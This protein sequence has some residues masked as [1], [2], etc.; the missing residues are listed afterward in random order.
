[1]PKKKTKK[2]NIDDEIIIGYNTNITKDTP[3]KNSKKNNKNKKKNSGKNTKNNQKKKN[4]LQKFK[5]IMIAICKILLIIG[6]LV[7]IFA[8]LFI[9][10]V[11]NVT[12]IKVENANRIS[13]NT[14]ISLSEIQIGEN[15]FKINS[16]RIRSLI[17]HESYVEEIEVK[18]SFPGTVIITVTERTPEY[19]IE[20]E[21]KYIYIDKNGY[22]L[23]NNVEPLKLPILKGTITD[24]GT[25][26]MGERLYEEDLSK[27][28]DLIKIMD[29]LKNNN[30]SEKI[31]SIDISNDKNY[32]LEFNEQKKSVYLGDISNLSTK[33]LWIKYFMEQSKEGSGIVHLEA[34]NVYFSP[35]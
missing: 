34:K 11:F 26:T 31:T 2:Y 25:L 32:I 13:E 14:Y 5:K 27:F 29:G 30:I 9:S 8:F 20:K 18:K 17:K 33:M 22:A 24:F 12:E 6:I 7:G 15:I 3:Q 4:R 23:E 21:G 10:P 16:S 19:I 35:N 28:N 1:M